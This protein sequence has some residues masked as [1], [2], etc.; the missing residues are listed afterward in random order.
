MLPEEFFPTDRLLVSAFSCKL[1][2]PEGMLYTTQCTHVPP[3]ASGS[4]AMSAYD[5][6]P[7]GALLQARA[8]E[9]LLPLQLY[10]TGMDCPFA[11]A[12]LLNSIDIAASVGSEVAVLADEHEERIMIDTKQKKRIRF[13]RGLLASLHRTAE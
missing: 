10:F 7:E 13:M 2:V 11:N 5:C 9:M 4:S 3:G 12:S 8:G 6:V 1:V